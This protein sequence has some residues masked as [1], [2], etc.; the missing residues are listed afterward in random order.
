MWMRLQSQQA[1]QG[2][3]SLSR[4]GTRRKMG[5]PPVAAP[6]AG[7]AAPNAAPTSHGSRFPPIRSPGQG[8]VALW[9][10]LGP[11]P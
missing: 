9:G 8:R 7:D 10:L 5:T 11:Q 2:E 6:S 3:A 1:P 4:A